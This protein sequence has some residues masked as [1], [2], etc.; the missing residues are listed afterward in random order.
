MSCWLLAM[1]DDIDWDEQ[2]APETSLEEWAWL[3]MRK[4]RQW[5][6]EGDDGS[7]S[8]FWRRT[9]ERL[10]V[11]DEELRLLRDLTETLAVRDA[12][13][14]VLLTGIAPDDARSDRDFV[15]FS[16][17]PPAHRQGWC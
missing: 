3:R 11:T 8:P 5:V 6:G 13:R 4:L 10:D 9:R 15:E 14:S 17:G 7:D 2:V 16:H 12:Y 1:R